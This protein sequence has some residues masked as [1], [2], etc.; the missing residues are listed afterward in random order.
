M[1]APRLVLVTDACDGCLIVDDVSAELA[2]DDGA[3]SGSP[4]ERCVEVYVM[5]L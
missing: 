4:G 5:I 1:Q 2:Q 3:W